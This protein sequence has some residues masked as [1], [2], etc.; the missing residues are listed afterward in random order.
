MVRNKGIMA[1]NG[2]D[3]ELRRKCMMSK[4]ETTNNLYK[5]S[6]VCRHHLMVVFNV[7]QAALPSFADAH[8]MS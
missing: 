8:C 6:T 4:E 7:F 5:L 2:S 3:S 1:S